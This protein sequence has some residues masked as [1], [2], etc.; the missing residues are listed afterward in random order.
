MYDF[1]WS[2]IWEYG[3]FVAS[4]IPTTLLVAVGAIALGMLA[5]VP[6]GMLMVRSWAPIRWLISAYVEVFRN[7]PVLVQVVWFYYVLP[8][9]TGNNVPGIQAGIIAIGLNASAYLADI[10]RGGIVGMPAGQFEAARSLGMS[11]G[12]TMTKVIL[13]QTWRRMVAPFS[14]MFV[15]IIKET[16]LVSYIG[17]LDVLHRGDVVQVQTF[18]PL[19]AYT[20]VAVFYFLLVTASTML[21]KLVEKRWSPAV[22]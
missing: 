16:A 9:L 7:T 6:L 19:E 8:I 22:E 15:V 21:M 5:G 13:P 11:H 3:G 1:D 18:K 20:L 4:G 14:N 10:V 2:I 17:V 12:Q